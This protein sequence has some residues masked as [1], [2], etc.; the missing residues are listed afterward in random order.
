MEG[1]TD[2]PMRELLTEMG[3]FDF[4]V[5]EFLRVSAEIP[6]SRVFRRHVPE[7]SQGCRTKAGT[8]TQVQL[9]GGNPQKLAE[10]AAR[11]VSLGV[12]AI[13]LNFGCPAP[14]VNRHDGGATLLKYP[15]RIEAI[16]TAVR[17][18]VPDHIPVSAKL[19][20]GWDSVDSIFVNAE[21][22][23]AGGASWLTIHA[24]TRSQGYAPPAHWRVIGEVAKNIDVPVV[25]NGDIWTFNDF[26]RCRD[27]TQ[28][29]HFMLGRGA[30]A[31]PFLPHMIA[32]E[33]KINGL[34]T[35]L[36]DRPF[37]TDIE[38]WLPLLTR[39]AHIATPYAIGPK[40][41][42]QKIKQWLNLVRLKKNI[43]W[44]E[45]IKRVETVPEIFQ[46]MAQ[47]ISEAKCSAV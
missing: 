3:G 45:Q 22:A 44:F 40:F 18:A 39:F 15:D 29:S 35:P 32:N 37:G 41:V 20:L 23:V 5:T 25:A 17:K 2:A 31:D 42:S 4:C 8:P 30:L 19:R 13:D 33:L 27:E 14:T 12:Q 11:A 9:L 28:C 21:R 16:V 36:N 38:A 24:R 34:K 43:P 6:P 46:V 47:C 10:S 26:L 7:I 1:V